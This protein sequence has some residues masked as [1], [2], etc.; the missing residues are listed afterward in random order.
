M[1]LPPGCS[2]S[3]F[4]FDDE[5]PRHGMACLRFNRGVDDRRD[6]EC[7]CGADEEPEPEEDDEE[8]PSMA[9]VSNASLIAYHANVLRAVTDLMRRPA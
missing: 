1:A 5:T 7:I 2:N 9:V 4:D 6:A 3:D 8:T